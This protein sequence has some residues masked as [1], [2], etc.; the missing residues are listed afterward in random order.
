MPVGSVLK[1]R[2]AKQNLHTVSA[3]SGD[4]TCRERWKRLVVA[5][6]VTSMVCRKSSLL[7]TDILPHTSEMREG[8]A[9]CT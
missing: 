7:A 8:S 9:M 6:N 4:I 2:V 5:H 1:S 3:M